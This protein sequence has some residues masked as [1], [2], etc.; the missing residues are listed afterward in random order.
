MECAANQGRRRGATHR[1]QSPQARVD[2]W[3]KYW[4][5]VVPAPAARAHISQI[6]AEGQ[7][8][9]PPWA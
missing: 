2:E 7:G 1:E 5:A 6:S 9:P 4:D 8:R 3:A